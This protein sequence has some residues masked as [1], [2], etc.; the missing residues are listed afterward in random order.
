M[1]TDG[2]LA[3]LNNALLWSL[4]RSFH[5]LFSLFFRWSFKSFVTILI[6]FSKPSLRSFLTESGYHSEF[7]F[8]QFRFDLSSSVVT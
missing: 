5:N 7:L 1:V 3:R 6:N 8:D 2:L 4:S